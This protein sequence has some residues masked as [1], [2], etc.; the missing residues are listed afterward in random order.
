VVTPHPDVASGRYQQAEFAADL[1]QVYQKE[2]SD[3]YKHPAEFFRRTF[4]TGG[5]KDLLVAALRRLAGQGGDPVVELQTNFGGGKTHSMLALYHL[6]GGTPAADLPGADELVKQAGVPVTAGVRRVVLVGTRISP[7]QPHTKPDGTTVR[8]LWGELAWQL[9]GKEGYRLVKQADETATSPGDA[10]TTLFNKYAPCLVLIDE[11]VAYARQLHDEPGQ[12]PAGTFDTQFTFAQALTECA[13]AAK[14]TLLVLSIPASEEGRTQGAPVSDME[15]G[16]ERGRRALHRLKNAVGRVESSWRP[17]NADEGFEIVRRRLFQPLS[18]DGFA[19]RDAVARAFAELYAAQHNEFPPACREGEYERRIKLAYPIHPELFDRLYTDWSA[20]EKFQRTRGVL[21]LMA[22]VIHALWERQDGNLLILPATVPV[23][24]SGVQFELTRY[25]EDPWVPV[26]EKDVDGPASLPLAL[27]REHPTLGRYSACR[28]VARTLYLGSAPTQRAAHRGLDDQR[29]KLGCVQPGEVVA[30]FGDALRRLSDRATYLYADGKR[31]WYATTPTVTRLAEDRAHQLKEHDV[32]DEIVR[33][34]R[35]EAKTRGDFARARACV[36]SGDIPDEPEVQLV[37]LGPEYPHAARDAGSPARKQAAAVLDSR[38]AGPRTNRNALVFLAADGTRLKEL[39]QAVRQF[40]AWSSIWDDRDTLNLDN[41]QNRQAETRRKSAEETVRARIPET[42]QWL[43]V[44]GQS[45]PRGEI[46]WTDLRLQ[47]GDALA[48]RA[49]KK[50]RNEELLLI[51]L[52]GARLRH[53]LDRVPLWRGEHVS[54]KQLTEDMARY[55]YLPRLRDAEVL[56]EAIEDG[57]GRLS[58]QAETFAYAEGWD[59]ARKRYVG[60]KT[61]QAVPVSAGSPALLVR[62]EAAAKQLAA[63]A[64]ERK[65]EETDSGDHNGK[66]RSGRTEGKGKEKTVTE[67]PPPKLRRFH[68]TVSLDPLRVGRDAAAIAQEVIQH[69]AGL[70]GARVRVTLE[71]AAD[72]GD[73]APDK[74]VRD[75]SENCRTLKFESHGFEEA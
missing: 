62:P 49:A 50:L 37:V 16:G 42:Y 40:L 1:W 17:A 39:E 75:V 66:G 34:L 43:I 24:D 26:I 57:L 63:E 53:E 33:R 70:V 30:T 69:L 65:R 7:G 18:G 41:F 5:L 27:D 59:D 20:L 73:G 46:E 15:I 9:G 12:L 68:G 45:D 48:V 55:L 52:G 13:K 10:L 47:G 60:L 28:R 8:T 21:R 4:L 35:D 74:V 6:F 23:D 11:W 58:W 22:A 2:G 25:V 71:I 29:V 32:A 61:G 31:Y 64:A 51:Q 36:P 72:L 56:L 19:A 3:E 54:V 38:G 67:P 14:R 44:P